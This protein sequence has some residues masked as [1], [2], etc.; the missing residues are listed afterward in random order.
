M[1]A[2][3]MFPLLPPTMAPPNLQAT[4]MPPA[5]PI[6]SLPA[7]YESY[8]AMMGASNVNQRLIFK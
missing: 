1:F 3:G 4:A 8:K 5:N 2:P 7:I 6:Y